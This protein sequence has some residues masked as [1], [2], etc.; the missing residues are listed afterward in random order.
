MPGLRQI[1][2]QP[3]ALASRLAGRGLVTGDRAAGI[4]P[5]CGNPG[6]VSGPLRLWRSRRAPVFEGRWG[7]SAPCLRSMVEAAV[8]R[9]GRSQAE[10][11]LRSHRIPL[12]LMLLDQGR[13]TEEQLQ[14]ARRHRIGTAAAG[15]EAGRVEAWLLDSGLLS[16]SALTRAIS[17]QWNCPVFSLSAHRDETGAAVPPFLAEALGA[18][19]LR[20]VGGRVLYVAFAE[21]IDRS[22]SYAIEHVTGLR[23]AA[24]MARGSEFRREQIRF[25][26]G[27]APR[28]RL[29]EA[30]DRHAL[31]Q[32]MAGWIEEERAV[33]ARLA[34]VHEF[35]WLRIWR[36]EEERGGLPSCD[37][38]EDLLATA[39]GAVGTT[40][41]RALEENAV[42]PI[43]NAEGSGA[44]CWE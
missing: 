12:H 32:R 16:E 27:R 23:V 5:R 7:C 8:D 1:F 3:E 19:P 2:R 43:T 20:V 33:E 21:Q 6:C 30:E 38:V 28:A 22:L 34:R 26:A 4:F 10:V 17:A 24:G 11:A 35:W 44:S 37:A 31:A 14:E 42:S 15:E 36:R 25:L 13:I 18:L 41:A 39:G 29:M 9:E 40:G